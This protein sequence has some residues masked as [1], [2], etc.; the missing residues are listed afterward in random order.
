MAAGRE[1]RQPDFL[2]A[3]SAID[4][5]SSAGSIIRHQLASSGQVARIATPLH[6]SVKP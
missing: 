3:D 4:H 2:F 6:G 1:G 5:Y